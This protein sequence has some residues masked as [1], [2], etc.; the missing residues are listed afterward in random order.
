MKITI[1][2]FAGAAQQARVRAIE[3]ELRDGATVAEARDHC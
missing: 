2:L 1:R 3:V